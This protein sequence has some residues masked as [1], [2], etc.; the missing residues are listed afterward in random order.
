MDTD[1]SSSSSSSEEELVFVRRRKIYRD[2]QNYYELYDDLDFF[3]RFRLTKPTVM[4]VLGE[5]EPQ[6][7]LP[8]NRFV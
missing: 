6:I 2:R 8:T 4:Q 1:T 3:C 7:R 5:I